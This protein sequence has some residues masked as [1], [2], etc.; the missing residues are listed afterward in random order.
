MWKRVAAVIVVVIAFAGIA[1]AR[2]DGANTL[3]AYEWMDYGTVITTDG[4]VIR[5]DGDGKA[6]DWLNDHVSG[7]PV[8]AEAIVILPRSYGGAYACGG[9]RISR[10]TGLPTVMGWDRHE[11][12]QRPTTDFQQRERDIYD[13]YTSTNI[14]NKRRVI[15]TYQIEYI[16]SGPL[17]LI[18]PT[19]DGYNHCTSSGSAAGIAALSA[20]VGTDLEIV[21]SEDGTTVY[22][23]QP[24]TE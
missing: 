4:Q 1:I 3:N 15:D 8:I 5:Y 10:S 9:A 23:V 12:Q 2:L 18:Y 21:F 6:I 13:L 20:M 17:E 14:A 11:A 24:S 7:S 22:H 19:T 16:V